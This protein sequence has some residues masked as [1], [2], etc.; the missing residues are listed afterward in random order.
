VRELR[1]QGVERKQAR[2]IAK[3]EHDQETLKRKKRKLE[4]SERSKQDPR[5][6]PNL[7]EREFPKRVL[8]LNDPDAILRQDATLIAK[9]KGITFEKAMVI[10]KTRKADR[11]QQSAEK[12]KAKIENITNAS[13]LNTIPKGA[14]DGIKKSL[15]RAPVLRG[16]RP[17]SIRSKKNS[18][19]RPNTETNR[20]PRDPVNTDDRDT[21]RRR[22]ATKIALQEGIS[23]QKAMGLAKERQKQRDE[24]AAKRDRVKTENRRKYPSTLNKISKEGRKGIAK[25]LNQTQKVRSRRSTKVTYTCPICS[26][27]FSEAVSIGDGQSKV[28]IKIELQKKHYRSVHNLTQEEV[29]ERIKHERESKAAKDSFV[30][31]PW[32][33]LP[34]DHNSFA[35][36]MSYYKSIEKEFYSK[37]RQRV[38]EARLEAILSLESDRKYRCSDGFLGYLVL[39][40]ERY[41]K[42]ILECPIYGNAV[43]L[44][45]KNSWK[46]QARESKK[47]IRENYPGSYKRVQH[48]DGWLQKVRMELR[49][50]VF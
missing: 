46:L 31:L 23:H 38:D 44:L 5:A 10:A 4:I 17:Y 15:D 49:S 45:Y 12:K 6:W 8:T 36:L 24:Q 14:K 50:S 47:Y 16:E 40:F 2:E 3:H 18:K 26:S 1:E 37:H 22:E 29:S 11:L 27:N 34:P 43:Y 30:V 21:R 42:V 13:T 35:G 9:Q 33:I 41:E 20:R 32:Q 28:S 39:E 48:T 19:A 25:G 7:G